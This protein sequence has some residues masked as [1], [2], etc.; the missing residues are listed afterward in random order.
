MTD[1]VS[2]LEGLPSPSSMYAFAEI[3]SAIGSAWMSATSIASAGTRLLAV[4][5]TVASTM[6]VSVSRFLSES[7]AVMLIAAMG[8]SVAP[9]VVLTSS[10]NVQLD[11]ESEYPVVSTL[12]AVTYSS[13][14]GVGLAVRV[15]AIDASPL[16]FAVVTSQTN[17]WSSVSLMVTRLVRAASVR[18]SKAVVDPFWVTPVRAARSVPMAAANST[19]K[20]SSSASE[21]DCN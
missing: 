15:T 19:S 21:S 9:S 11:G 3:L 13:S 16:G 20:R 2:V 5:A 18:A 12:S 17:S 14:L 8:P 4:P 7:G 6:I 10:S 1:M